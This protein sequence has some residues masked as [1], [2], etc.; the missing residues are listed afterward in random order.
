MKSATMSPIELGKEAPSAQ[1]DPLERSEDQAEAADLDASASRARHV[2]A[3]QSTGPHR[4]TLI[5]PVRRSVS[6][7]TTRAHVRRVG[8]RYL[9]QLSLTT[10]P[11]ILID[12]ALLTLAIGAS[13]VAVRYVGIGTGIDT[14]DFYIPIV[15]GFIF[16]GIE[17]GLY[18]GIRLG[19]VEEFRRLAVS[20]TLIFGMWTVG[21]ILLTGGLRN[22]PVFLSLAY[23]LSLMNLWVFRGFARR[24]LAKCSW[25]G[26]PTLVC[27]DDAVAVKVYHWLDVNKR[28][29]LRPAGVIADPNAP[30]VDVNEPWYAGPWSAAREIAQQRGAYWAVVVPPE[31]DSAPISTTI[32]EHLSTIPHI[33]ILSELTGLPDHWSRHQQLDGLA[34]IHLQ[35]NLMLPLPRISKR[36]MDIVLTLVGGLVLLPL[37]FYIAVAVKMS[38]RGPVLYANERIGRDGRRFRMWKFR[39]MFTNGDAVLEEYLEMHPEYRHEWETT[40]KLRWDPRITRIGR[41]IRKTSLDELPQMW[42][43]LRGDMSLVGPRPILLDEEA[44]YG[45]YYGLYTMVS[46]GITG[47]WQVSGR[48]NTSY[49]ERLQLVAYYVRNWSLWLDI[50]L[51]LKTVRIVLF[52]RGAY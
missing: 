40:Q 43:V 31:G 4:T 41:F 18:P 49:E 21:V 19:P 45:D 12:V 6:G 34:G 39:S 52:G 50:Y 2:P 28:L 16:I 29:G 44:K 1:S 7:E 11:L 14:S 48:S 23:V 38:S 9:W 42:N 8:A 33:H 24:L 27:G 32:T 20:A 25:W 17:L 13:W 5:E 51:L 22:Q 46:P 10:I 3:F 47:M 26:F 35:Q 15:I 30:E 36:L 37:L